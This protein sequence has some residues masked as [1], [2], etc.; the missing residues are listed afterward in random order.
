[1]LDRI[2]T[3]RS[4]CALLL[5][6]VIL[7][8][9]LVAP[10][11]MAQPSG[12]PPRLD[13]YT[14]PGMPQPTDQSVAQQLKETKE[15][16]AAAAKGQDS[17]SDAQKN[18]TDK[19]PFAQT[20]LSFVFNVIWQLAIDV[21]RPLTKALL[22]FVV[23]N[24]HNPNV[25]SV[26]NTA[27]ADGVPNDLLTMR[28]KQAV[29]LGFDYSRALAINLLLLLF[30]CSIW[31]YWIDASW[32]NGQAL[33]GAVARLIAATALILA[34]PTISYHLVEC[35]NE[36]TDYMFRTI[37]PPQLELAIG[38]VVGLATIESVVQLVLGSAVKTGAASTAA[39][40]GTGGILLNGL[41]GVAGTLFYFVFLF[42]LLTQC[43]YFI[44]LRAV[45]IACML[46]Q[47][48]FA[49][50]FLVF[51]AHPASEK[52]AYTFMRSCI[53]VSLWT[54]AWVGI[55][56]LL[57]MVL[58]EDPQDFAW[59]HGLM[60]LGILQLMI[61]VPEFIA[62][63]Q[64]SP[65]SDFL[66]PRGVFGALT[67]A[68]NAATGTYRALRDYHST[69][70]APTP[71]SPV[72]PGAKPIGGGFG[73]GAGGGAG[74]P[75]GGGGGPGG[76]SGGPGGGTPIATPA[77][78]R[79]GPTPGGGSPIAEG[80][81]TP[82]GEHPPDPAG[83]PGRRSGPGEAIPAASADLKQNLAKVD[84]LEN[85]TGNG[86]NKE[87][88]DA[89]RAA[90]TGSATR[91]QLETARAA[92][93][94]IG[95]AEASRLEAGIAAATS[96]RE[97]EDRSNAALRDAHKM[98]DD[99][100]G[101][102][103][104]TA[105]QARTL[106]AQLANPLSGAREM[107][108]DLS[109]TDRLAGGA[110]INASEAQS[111]KAGLNGTASSA[112][113]TE[114]ITALE[115]LQSPGGELAAESA[116]LADGIGRAQQRAQKTAEAT[117]AL[118]D[119][120]GRKAITPEQ[121]SS[122]S[123]AM[124]EANT[125]FNQ[126]A[127]IAA[128]VGRGHLTAEQ[129]NLLNRGLSGQLNQEEL[130]RARQLAGDLQSE[131]S[132]TAA[133][134]SELS[135]LRDS[136]SAASGLGHIDRAAALIEKA[137]AA[138]GN[139]MSENQLNSLYCAASGLGNS[140]KAKE[141]VT[142]SV[143]AGWLNREEA[144]EL[145]ASFADAE[146][147]DKNGNQLIDEIEPA[148]GNVDADA[149][150]D[151]LNRG[152][153]IATAMSI[154]DRLPDTIDSG[155][156]SQLRD[157]IARSAAMKAQAA[158]GAHLS[159]MS[160]Q[161]S[162]SPEQ[163]Q[164]ASNLLARPAAGSA[165][166]G[167][168]LSQVERLARSGVI[169]TEQSRVLQ[170]ALQGDR[171][172]TDNA[173]AIANGLSDSA[174]TEGLQS[175]AEH[176]Q[177]MSA[178]RQM[179]GEQNMN[180][181]PDQ[182]NSLQQSLD[183]A[184]SSFNEAV[185]LQKQLAD[186][187]SAGALE[188]DDRTTLGNALEGS[189]SPGMLRTAQNTALSRAAAS[190][191]TADDQATLNNVAAAIGRASQ[192]GR[193][194]QI[195]S[196]I[197]SATTNAQREG[198][199]RLRSLLTSPTAGAARI[200]AA[201]ARVASMQSGGSLDDSAA[202][203]MNSALGGNLA[204][205]SQARTIAQR[206]PESGAI[207]SAL[208][209]AER[210][211][212]DMEVAK[213]FWQNGNLDSVGSDRLRGA[214][215]EAEAEFQ[216]ARSAS[217]TQAEMGL[218]VADRDAEPRS[219]DGSVS[220]LITAAGTGISNGDVASAYGAVTNP[221][222]AS[223]MIASWQKC[224]WLNEEQAGHFRIPGDRPMSR[225]EARA[226]TGLS[227]N[228][229]LVDQLRTV[230]AGLSASQSNA[231]S[232]R[233][234]TMAA[235]SDM[236]ASSAGSADM[237]NGNAR[238]V[239]NALTSN[240]SLSQRVSAAQEQI[241]TMAVNGLIREG[242]AARMVAGVTSDVSAASN[243][244][245]IASNIAALPSHELSAPSRANIIERLMG[246]GTPLPVTPQLSGM[247]AGAREVVSALS[248]YEEQLSNAQGIADA[249]VAIGVA[250]Y[251]NARSVLQRAHIFTNPDGDHATALVVGNNDHL[252]SVADSIGATRRS[253]ESLNVMPREKAAMANELIEAQQALVQFVQARD[254]YAMARGSLSGAPASTGGSG[255]SHGAAEASDAGTSSGTAGRV[256]SFRAPV[257]R[258][259]SPA[260]PST[261]PGNSLDNDVISN[262]AA[263]LMS[264]DSNQLRVSS[265]RNGYHYA[266]VNGSGEVIE[267]QAAAGATREQVALGLF[268]TFMSRNANDP[269]ARQAIAEDL[270]SS[271]LSFPTSGNR[272]EIENYNRAA[273]QY[274]WSQAQE[275]VCGRQAQGHYGQYLLSTHGA[276]TQERQIAAVHRLVNPEA[277]SSPFNPSYR[278]ASQRCMATGLPQTDE[279]MAAA[280]RVD[281]RLPVPVMRENMASVVEFASQFVP[282]DGRSALSRSSSIAETI[283]AINNW[284]SV[285][286]C[287]ASGIPLSLENLAAVERCDN[288]S[289]GKELQRQVAAVV[290]YGD[291][292]CGDSH[293]DA[294]TRPMVLSNFIA[295][296][297]DNQIRSA[298]A[299]QNVAG[300]AFQD[301]Q[302]VQGVATLAQS[303]F[304]NNYESA[305][306]GMQIYC[307]QLAGS[308]GVPAAYGS[309]A[310]DARSIISQLRQAGFTED[311]VMNADVASIMVPFIQS[312]A[313]GET[314]RS[315]A[316][317]LQLLGT[318]GF[319]HS[320]V[321]IVDAMLNNRW[322]RNEISRPDV[323]LAR[324]LVMQG[325]RP[326]RDAVMNMRAASMGVAVHPPAR[327][328][329]P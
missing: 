50:L 55:L 314:L 315:A 111:I 166:V 13:V 329:R 139:D 94:R 65:V 37:S 167:K 263:R 1:M 112:Q 56:R 257:I 160:R 271:G 169:G 101:A 104:L 176:G 224:D 289:S 208:D 247:N 34:W 249:G 252:R 10:A 71:T 83:G 310:S 211:A 75:A 62:K 285:E 254:Q 102:N 40:P 33:M 294:A 288:R 43:I 68:L 241:S 280:A 120:V 21:M 240:P 134:K 117:N 17:R 276:M 217:R 191:R 140:D 180:M 148:I 186:M 69:P 60:L 96:L 235:P 67:G 84:E 266:V 171:A 174:L 63:A 165:S 149:L 87:E 100:E 24:L 253:I 77:P 261:P 221:G 282:D 273:G 143:D 290:A 41:Q 202:A 136:L 227:Q 138:A 203:V 133:Q 170:G 52:H 286:R 74:G 16:Q 44:V 225:P 39:A 219:L 256:D 25:A 319:N 152:A 311:Q 226:V 113:L 236:V 163:Y 146:S 215:D 207:M 223:D 269:L 82:G 274:A 322:S 220:N 61:K 108:R 233:M 150:R 105:E 48:M 199:S 30:I 179:S 229:A 73:A 324:A 121:A 12:P 182:A 76:G 147:T 264:N 64:I 86:L 119:L 278:I 29:R 128:A 79:P 49:P 244:I 91:E 106:K 218:P 156:K 188:E 177:M 85:R 246:E 296:A 172:Q 72:G 275:Y 118:Q 129:G 239:R 32:R 168:A 292:L 200:G 181:S 38:R 11:S 250:G 3:A 155:K 303:C 205:L 141:L 97:Q 265:S 228:L 213:C 103:L 14:P 127:A 194:S 216:D 115:R 135:G 316:V 267:F 161:K 142:D 144:D 54:F 110:H 302:V 145:D 283:N 327:A 197:E 89:L 125:R 209:S 245:A 190:G 321:M 116:Q 99:M 92:L 81:P 312:N 26:T 255:A 295:S 251:D 20:W 154:L 47:F 46:A 214:V 313:G 259:A 70:T 4:L 318:G 8:G 212:R 291:T 184:D 178:A 262:G 9:A 35:S 98:I 2:A 23:T 131:P 242:V 268:G 173:R 28:Q 122:I 187:T 58:A 107:A 15:G 95:G 114:A 192:R 308:D 153:N 193:V 258:N 304:R 320:D 328:M 237:Q 231:V 164:A 243:A 284:R 151:T 88:A 137:R 109:T 130:R 317:A 7:G 175:A 183:E 189:M 196:A 325:E 305:A 90:L 300:H 124:T 272:I 162:V 51:L 157:A 80:S 126:A 36:M 270:Q 123:A 293:I 309:V 206:L 53:E 66:T 132:L 158:N 201:Q 27:N 185:G 6:I 159:R 234:H 222:Q 238:M 198:D 307:T 301:V 230:P 299:V 298:I 45:A 195:R 281:G 279:Y 210:H 277:P 260:S 31:K 22:H 93:N 326:T 204:S 42:I 5:S 323:D 232:Q 78:R 306:R 19:D 59:G 57:V 18:A 287:Q 248:R 297:K